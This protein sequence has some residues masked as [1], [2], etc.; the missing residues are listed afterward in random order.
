LLACWDGH[1]SSLP[2]DTADQVFRFLGVAGDQSESGNRIEVS[3]VADDLEVAARLVAMGAVRR[4]ADGASDG[5]GQPCY[6]LFAGD[7]VLEVQQSMPP[8]FERR[9]ADLNEYNA[10]FERVVAD[11]RLVRGESL[12]GDSPAMMALSDASDL[13]NIDRQF[14]KADSLA[15]YMQRRSDRLFNAFAITAFAMGL[16]YLIYDKI[17]ESKIAPD[18]LRA[19]PVREL[20]GVLLR[21]DQTLVRK[22]P[23]IPRAGRNTEGAVLSGR[24][25]R[26][27]AHA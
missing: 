18:V 9:L 3:P 17:T 21:S 23:V 4:G 26:G 15:G 8:S 12:L 1:S 11:G 22:I 20:A 27:S 19:H 2:N 16:A 13:E 10:E 14:V 24:G 25:G 7:S 5:V 6:L